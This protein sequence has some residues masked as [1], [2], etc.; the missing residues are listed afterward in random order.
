MRKIAVYIQ[1]ENRNICWQFCC[2]GVFSYV[3]FHSVSRRRSESQPFPKGYQRMPS[4]SVWQWQ[5][6][7]RKR[8]RKAKVRA[9]SHCLSEET[10]PP[11]TA[12]A[13]AAAAMPIARAPMAPKLGHA[14]FF[15]PLCSVLLFSFLSLQDHKEG[16]KP[17]L[18]LWWCSSR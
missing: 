17:S 9:L 8:R 5:P 12:V 2:L 3:R 6:I 14:V 16:R 7:E 10:R 4:I 1:L 15:R 13:V 11:A 18:S